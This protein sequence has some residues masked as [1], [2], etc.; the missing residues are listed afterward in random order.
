MVITGFISPTGATNEPRSM[1]VES[2]L[3]VRLRLAAE[4][5]PETA[6][7]TGLY[8]RDDFSAISYKVY[9]EVDGVDALVEGYESVAVTINDAIPASASLPRDW[10]KDGVGYNFRHV[11]PAAAF[12]ANATHRVVYRFVTS[13]DSVTTQHCVTV[14]VQGPT[15]DTASAGSGTVTGEPG[16]AGGDGPGY[17]A[18]SVTSLTIGTGSKSF[19]TQEGLAYTAGARVRTSSEADTSNWMEGLCTSYSGTSLVVNVTL[20]DGSGTHSDWNINLAGEPGDGGGDPGPQGEQGEPG[21]PGAGFRFDVTVD[22]YN[23]DPDDDAATN[24][25]AIQAALDAAEQWAIDNPG[26]IPVVYVPD[27]LFPCEEIEVNGN[28]ALSI[29]GI[30]QLPSGDTDTGNLIRVTGGGRV[31]G[32]VV[33]M[34][35]SGDPLVGNGIRFEGADGKAIGVRVIN[36]KRQGITALDTAIRTEIED[37]II[38]GGPLSLRIRDP[39]CRVRRCKFLNFTGE[40]AFIVDPATADATYFEMSE[41]Y[42]YTSHGGWEA[43]GLVD[44][45]DGVIDETGQ[46]LCGALT[47]HGGKARYAIQGGHGFK[48]GDGFWMFTSGYAT[49]SSSETVDTGTRVF[50]VASGLAYVANAPIR[51]T[52][53]DGD[54]VTGVVTSYSGTTLTIAAT[55][56][57]GSGTK[58]SWVVSTYAWDISHKILA[59]GGDLFVRVK[60]PTTFEL[61]ASAR[62]A[63][64][65]TDGTA[66]A[67][68]IDLGTAGTTGTDIYFTTP[69][70]GQHAVSTGTGIDFANELLTTDDEHGFQTGEPVRLTPSMLT[71]QFPSGLQNYGWVVLNS[72]YQ[73]CVDAGAAGITA[74]YMR[75]KRI[76]KV[77]LDGNVF[78]APNTSLNAG[79]L[80]KVHNTNSLFID[81]VL[82]NSIDDSLLSS[83]DDIQSLRLGGNNRDVHLR[84]MRLS[85]GLFVQAFSNIT[86][87]YAEKCE[88]GDGFNITNSPPVTGFCAQVAKFF[89]CVLRTGSYCVEM[90][91]R[92]DDMESWEFDACEFRGYTSGATRISLF[93][94]AG[95]YDGAIYGGTQMLRG[96]KIWLK[97]NCKWGTEGYEGLSVPTLT[98]LTNTLRAT[99]HGLR[100]GDMVYF[101]AGTMPENMSGDIPYW[102]R[103]TDYRDFKIY[104]SRVDADADT[105]VIDIVSTGAG[106]GSAVVMHS[107]DGKLGIQ[108]H[109]SSTFADYLLR[110]LNSPMDIQAEDLTRLKDTSIWVP[111]GLRVWKGKVAESASPGWVCTTP[112]NP[113]AGPATAAVFRAMP[114][115]LGTE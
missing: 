47:N 95:N 3:V 2:D 27:E 99:N 104:P 75:P 66:P 108:M 59:C 72:N 15:G 92:D 90:D 19:T 5:T 61:Y 25:L 40:K 45:G 54:Y 28:V 39:N 79:C 107:H 97:P 36:A 64:T 1:W 91:Y 33:D 63:M 7:P 113:L 102:V 31:E 68:R 80:I 88:F 13:F 9:R 98:A 55:T 96:G 86:R 56:A 57:V 30:I 46:I 26:L 70:G 32:G 83:V 62:A 50:T 44:P 37:C 81:G 77:V 69:L 48:P 16:P 73:A 17:L 6:E 53:S 10:G 24:T 49:S 43:F 23:A 100:H 85:D 52:A 76:N 38:E 74:T 58:T 4:P 78:E 115:L 60:S 65:A 71:D 109:Q 93:R 51:V 21:P 18:T 35:D 82:Q 84:G 14:H 111:Y 87:F 29:R 89:Q 94:N 110:T 11:V 106:V 12:A 20:T 105:N 8:E 42:G 112:S 41:C 103:V 101:T 67:T 34:Q 22:P 114:A